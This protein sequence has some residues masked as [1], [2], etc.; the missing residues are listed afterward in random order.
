MP[1]KKHAFHKTKIHHN[2]WLAW[3]IAISIIVGTA[4][5][6]FI[7]VSSQNFETE[8]VPSAV[9]NWRLFAHPTYGFSLNLPHNWQAS[10]DKSAVASFASA[11][12]EREKLAVKIFEL[13]TESQIRTNFRTWKQTEIM[14][15]SVAALRF[16]NGSEKIIM[17]KHNGEIYVLRGTGLQFDKVASTFKFTR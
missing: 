11:A 12:D 17:A 2:R 6:G 16:A 10:E 15:D 7:K 4:L 9:F 3:A 8:I 5:V 13:D 1:K 14:L